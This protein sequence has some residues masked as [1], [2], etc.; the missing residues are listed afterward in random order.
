MSMI[1]DCLREIYLIDVLSTPFTLK[2]GSKNETSTHFSIMLTKLLFISVAIFFTL[3]M[4]TLISQEDLSVSITVKDLV[5][6]KKINM[7]SNNFIFAFRLEDYSGNP[8]LND[9]KLFNYFHFDVAYQNVSK[10]E[11]I[12]TNSTPLNYTKCQRKD[13]K[14]LEDYFDKNKLESAFCLT[15]FSFDLKGFWDEDE[16]GYFL[17]NME[18]CKN[19]T[20]NFTCENLDT[21]TALTP[22]SYMSLYIENFEYNTENMSFPLKKSMKNHFNILNPSF[23]HI[24]REF[25]KKVDILT[26]DNLLISNYEK[27]EFFKYHQSEK[28]YVTSQTQLFQY[29]LYTA[30]SMDTVT[31]KQKKIIN[32]LALV[33]GFS[34]FLFG[35]F[36]FCSK[37]FN[38]RQQTLDIINEIYNFDMREE[39]KFNNFDRSKFKHVSAEIAQPE[40]NSKRKEIEINQETLAN[41]HILTK[42]DDDKENFKFWQIN[43]RANIEEISSKSNENTEPK[44]NEKENKKERNQSEHLTNV[45]N[46]S[47]DRLN[48]NLIKLQN[49]KYS[50]LIF[51]FYE[52]IIVSLLPCLRSKRL[53]KKEELYKKAFNETNHYANIFGLTKGMMDIQKI[54]FL[55]LS[56]S[57]IAIFNFLSKPLIALNHRR[58]SYHK[59]G[60]KIKKMFSLLQKDDRAIKKICEYYQVLFK[61]KSAITSDIDVKLLEWLDEDMKTLFNE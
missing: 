30:D 7:N 51:S 54:K 34:Q 31:R 45:H 15:N 6:R 25:F 14:E 41:E 47:F 29:N 46:E 57:Q 3:Q 52:T 55:F 1:I 16:V 39:N 61:S 42:V 32:V 60:Y 58:N 21:V 36:F 10:Q 33:G 43:E 53:K 12:K 24:R 35:I 22:G 5:M 50:P 8:L 13:F 49:K 4:N 11:T 56:K 2:I 37:T 44:E 26:D 20:R 40:D 18:Y 38:K 59:S 19:S 17:L 48:S 23:A 27:Q 28:D 9:D